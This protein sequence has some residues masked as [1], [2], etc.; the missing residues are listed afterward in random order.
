MSDNILIDQGTDA[1]VATDDVSSVHYQKIKVALGAD[2]A[3]DTLLDSG[4]QTMANSV[5]VVVASNQS[6]IPITLDSE[7]VSI[8]SID[9][10][11]NNIG[12][13]DLA[14]ALPSGTNPI[15]KLLP[16]DIDITTHTN[17]A[18]KYYTSTGS[19][20]DGI[21]WSPAAGKRWHILTLYIQVSAASTV[22][23]EDDKVAGDDAVWKGE[24]AANS[25]VVL[26]FS[27]R[28]PFASGEDAADLIITTTAGNVYVTAVGYEI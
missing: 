23:L 20:T 25:G 24:L 9:A 4:Q 7:K 18:K 2:G 27:E 26:N 28:Y 14:S 3:V 1:S 19:V 13:V 16:A 8:G 22:T 21:I 5:P 6:D 17:Y 10:G 15:G 12:N 11:D